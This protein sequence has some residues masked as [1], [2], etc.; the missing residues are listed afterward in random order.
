MLV[1]PVGGGFASSLSTY[2]KAITIPHDQPEDDGWSPSFRVNV[3]DLDRNGF[4]V[5]FTA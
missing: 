3:Q 5:A 4:H 1:D 2:S